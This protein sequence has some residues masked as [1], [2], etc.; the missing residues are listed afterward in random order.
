[1]RCHIFSESC[2]HQLSDL[3]FPN[4]IFAKCIFLSASPKLREFL[5]FLTNPR[6]LVEGVGRASWLAL[7]EYPLL[8]VQCLKFLEADSAEMRTGQL[9]QQSPAQRTILYT[10]IQIHNSHKYTNT[11]VQLYTQ[12]INI[13]MQMYTNH[14]NKEIHMYTIC[15]IYGNTHAYTQLTQI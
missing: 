6:L 13:Q 1:M 9:Y 3:N 12:V 10:N 2:D 7:L 14:T 4:C 5:F 8:A 15:K 11:N